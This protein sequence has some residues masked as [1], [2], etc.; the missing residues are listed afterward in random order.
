MTQST[1]H[2][3][4][5]NDSDSSNAAQYMPNTGMYMG[6]L[7]WPQP[8][9]I[10][11]L[12]FYNPDNVEPNAPHGDAPSYAPV[13]PSPDAG[14]GVE[15]HAF[16]AGPNGYYP[17]AVADVSGA[18]YVGPYPPLTQTAPPPQHPS[19]PPLCRQSFPSSSF[20]GAANPYTPPEPYQEY[21]HQNHAPW[22]SAPFAPLF[23]PRAPSLSVG[24]KRVAEGLEERGVKR[25]KIVSSRIKNDPLFK[26]VLDQHGQPN[27]TFVCSK[28]GIILNPES[29]LKHLK[30]KNH[31]GFKLE[32]YKCP[33]CIKTYARRDACKRHWDDEILRVLASAAPV[34]MPT[35]PVT[36]PTTAFTY[37]YPYPMPVTSMS[38]NGPIAF[39]AA[40]VAP[41]YGTPTVAD[42]VLC[43]SQSPENNMVTEPTEDED[44]DDEDDADFWEAN[45]IRD[46]DEM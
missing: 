28:D 39:P 13:A 26:P 3:S 1:S 15:H 5:S 43:L 16:Q 35:A 36:A 40:W 34:T 4:S 21:I 2:P 45:E 38:G 31:L 25:T 29:Y 37:S 8:A 10:P 22:L 18:T 19:A 23:V 42:P 24:K 30:T 20:P 32:R 46:T 27:G 9:Y 11:H 12:G 41:S 14:A 6:Q 44:E 7:P 33:G 17:P